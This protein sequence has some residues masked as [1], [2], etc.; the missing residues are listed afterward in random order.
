[1]KKQEFER[2]RKKERDRDRWIDRERKQRIAHWF[3]AA[4]LGRF[5]SLSGKGKADETVAGGE[6][7]RQ[8]C[9]ARGKL[10]GNF[11]GRSDDDE[12]GPSGASTNWKEIRSR[13]IARTPSEASLVNLF[14]NVN[15]SLSLFLSPFL[16][17]SFLILHYS[18][19]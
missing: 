9:D 6:E 14:P 19:M 2:E 16:F 15:L 18:S 7:R 12:A 11:D 17:L 4:D 1:M 3:T 8:C 5:F 13:S 10:P